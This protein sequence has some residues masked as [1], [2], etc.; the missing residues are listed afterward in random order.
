MIRILIV[1]ICPALDHLTQVQPCAEPNNL[2]VRVLGHSLPMVTDVTIMLLSAGGSV[3]V[4]KLRLYGQTG[5]VGPAS[6]ALAHV[7]HHDI[8]WVYER[9]NAELVKNASRALLGDGVC[10]GADRAHHVVYDASVWRISSTRIILVGAPEV[11]E[12]LE[13]YVGRN[14]I[15]VEV[16]DTAFGLILGLWGRSFY[17]CAGED[18]A[19]VTEP[20]D[21][22]TVTVWRGGWRLGRWQLVKVYIR[23]HDW[24]AAGRWICGISID[25]RA[26]S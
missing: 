18:D 4:E 9:L 8:E 12:I 16:H 7:S 11:G 19:A 23:W 17:P 22:P 20:Q 10:Q 15:V 1:I 3:M 2:G 21:R 14:G 24:G 5:V 25:G 13:I 26:C 6:D